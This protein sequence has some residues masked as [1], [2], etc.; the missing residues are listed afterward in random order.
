MLNWNFNTGFPIDST[1]TI[2]EMLDIAGL[3][4]NVR[5]FHATIDNAIKNGS[6]ED[7]SR[8]AIEAIPA[9]SFSSDKIRVLSGILGTLSG[10]LT[11]DD[12][13]TLFDKMVALTADFATREIPNLLKIKLENVLNKLAE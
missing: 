10:H 2:N 13:L 9:I 4:W 3:N 6:S 5:M 7:N 8:K 1:A 11:D 12:S